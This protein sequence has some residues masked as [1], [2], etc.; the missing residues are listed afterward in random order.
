MCAGLSETLESMY[1]LWSMEGDPAPNLTVLE[2]MN[3]DGEEYKALKN[4]LS[5]PIEQAVS[6]VS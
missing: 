1:P 4:E 2:A 5:Q 6:A 3:L